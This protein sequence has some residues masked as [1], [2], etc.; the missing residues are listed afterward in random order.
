MCNEMIF[1]ENL[2]NVQINIVKPLLEKD[3]IEFKLVKNLLIKA[4]YLYLIMFIFIIN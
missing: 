1:K 4:N 3:T 2:K